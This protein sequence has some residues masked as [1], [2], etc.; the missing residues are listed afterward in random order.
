[1]FSSLFLATES[2]PTATDEQ[3]ENVDDEIETT[4]STTTIE[5]N[6]SKWRMENKETRNTTA[7]TIVN[8]STEQNTSKQRNDSNNDSY[9]EESNNSFGT[10]SGKL[11][12]FDKATAATTIKQMSKMLERNL[13]KL[14]ADSGTVSFSKR[15]KSLKQTKLQVN[16]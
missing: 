3:I 16:S 10:D 5:A 12:L 11:A 1:M 13:K 9:E 8:S 7:I 4:I 14:G 6:N 15:P 2:S